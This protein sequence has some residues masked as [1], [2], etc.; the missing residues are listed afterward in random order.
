MRF[1]TLFQRQKGVGGSALLAIG[2]DPAPTST[3]ILQGTPPNAQQNNVLACK[4][5]DLNGWPVQRIVVAWSCDG[6]APVALNGDLFFWEDRSARWY[7]INDTALS[8]KPNQLFVFDTFCICAQ[9]P[10]QA[11]LGNP[12]SSAN[13]GSMEIMLVVSDPGA[14]VN[15]TYTFVMGPDVTTVGT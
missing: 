10:L 14:A 11:G 12:N 2:A 1:P 3:T 6:A 7:K 15:G 5:A 9:A 8:L 13:A 4:M